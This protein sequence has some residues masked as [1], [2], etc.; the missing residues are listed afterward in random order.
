M[1]Y[2]LTENSGNEGFF[3][4]P[5]HPL[6]LQPEKSIESKFFLSFQVVTITSSRI[7]FNHQTF[8]VPKMEVLTYVSSM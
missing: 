1:G 3:S 7:T 4:V 5:L 2:N 8:Q 6:H